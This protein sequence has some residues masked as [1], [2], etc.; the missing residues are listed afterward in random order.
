M[1]IFISLYP[2]ASIQN[3]LIN[4]SVVSEIKIFSI[5][6]MYP[7][8]CAPEH[9]YTISLPMAQVSLK[10][11]Q[12]LFPYIPDKKKRIE[13]HFPIFLKIT[14]SSVILAILFFSG[15]TEQYPLNFI[16]LDSTIFL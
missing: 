9:G 10:N 2:K 12:K 13:W 7:F 6:N 4:G 14:I 16:H 15:L 5:P 3:L 8:V 11:V 1:I